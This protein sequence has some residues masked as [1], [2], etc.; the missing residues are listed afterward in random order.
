M[1]IM[2]SNGV[3]SNQKNKSSSLGPYEVCIGGLSGDA[4]ILAKVEP[5][6]ECM[7]LV[8]C[9]SFLGLDGVPTNEIGNLQSHLQSPNVPN[10]HGVNN[11]DYA[12]YV[13]YRGASW[14]D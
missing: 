13:C 1:S 8:A 12:H 9:D 3:Y 11:L 4:P 2:T 6:G 10:G 7:A 14:M 5:D